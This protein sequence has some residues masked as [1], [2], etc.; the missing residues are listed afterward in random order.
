MA[1]SDPVV[2]FPERFFDMFQNRFDIGFRYYGP[3]AALISQLPAIRIAVPGKRGLKFGL[4]AIPISFAHHHPL[5]F[6]MS[7]AD[8]G[9]P[10]A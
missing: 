8:Y 7:G 2:I 6:L 9:S 10:A 3:F 5:Q 1:R 4:D